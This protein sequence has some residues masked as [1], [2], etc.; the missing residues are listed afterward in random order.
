MTVKNLIEGAIKEVDGLLTKHL[1][2]DP[3][4]IFVRLIE[5]KDKLYELS[6]RVS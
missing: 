5:L 6:R 1:D 4:N 3:L 2:R